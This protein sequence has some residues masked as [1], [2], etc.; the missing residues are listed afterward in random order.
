MCVTVAGSGEPTAA[1]SRGGVSIPAAAAAAAAPEG[2]ATVVTGPAATVAACPAV[3]PD[4]VAGVTGP[5]ATAAAAAGVVVA[6]GP[7]TGVDGSGF[8]RGVPPPPP[9]PRGVPPPPPPRDGAGDASFFVD[10]GATCARDV[11][12]MSSSPAVTSGRTRMRRAPP[13]RNRVL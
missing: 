10:M 7:A 1:A 8:A 2:P 11:T 4:P 13:S 5:T 9:L 3:A 6:G 12:V